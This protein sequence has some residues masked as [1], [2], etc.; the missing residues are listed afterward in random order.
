MN[1]NI[2][3]TNSRWSSSSQLVSLIYSRWTRPWGSVRI[4]LTTKA[5][6]SASIDQFTTIDTFYNWYW[7]R[8][9]TYRVTYLKYVLNY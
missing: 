1:T 7:Y 6:T 4:L 3:L 8:K 5:L 9:A 2:H